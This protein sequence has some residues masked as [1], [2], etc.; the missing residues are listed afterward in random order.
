MTGTR[1]CDGMGGHGGRGK[2]GENRR[3]D[4]RRAR[5]R[6]GDRPAVLV[7]AHMDTV[8]VAGWFDG[9]PYDLTEKEGKYFG[10]GAC[11][12]KASLAV[13]MLLARRLAQADTPLS[14]SLVFAATADE[15]PSN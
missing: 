6:P 13:F 5:N 9:S 1:D 2:N 7:E 8:G 10:R 14:H 3:G 11:D 15:S 12:T 4:R